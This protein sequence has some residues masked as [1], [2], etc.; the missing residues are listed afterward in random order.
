MFYLG[1]NY[2][3][4]R[5]IMSFCCFMYR[6]YYFYIINTNVARWSQR[7]LRSSNSRSPVILVP[8]WITTRV[9]VKNPCHMAHTYICTYIYLFIFLIFNSYDWY[10]LLRVTN[11]QYSH[12]R[13]IYINH[14]NNYIDLRNNLFVILKKKL[15][16][17]KKYIKKNWIYNLS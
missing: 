8:G 13:F 16:I 17:Q 14:I 9:L 2:S 12:I 6:L 3:L 5:D 7:V 10:L 1:R 15:N 4:K 11:L